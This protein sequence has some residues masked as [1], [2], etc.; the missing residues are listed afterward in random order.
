MFKHELKVKKIVSKESFVKMQR[1]V[2]MIEE[3]NKVMNL[4]GF[5][6]EDL[7]REG[8]YESL[9]SLEKIKANKMLDIGA[10]VG[11]PSIPFS[12]TN[13]KVNITIIEPIQKRVKFL[14]EVITKLNLNVKVIIGRVEESTFIEYFDFITARAVMSLDK[15]IEVSSAVGTIG[16][17]YWFIKGPKVKDELLKASK[18]SSLLNVKPKV[19][20]IN[21][22]TTIV[23]YTKDLRT[24]KGYPRRWKQIIK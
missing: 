4:T 3:K 1:Y 17:R 12:I 8:I 11:F 9:I 2:E 18:I 22:K 19:H 14:K 7:W 5:S 21:N 10:G 20:K 15:L 24:P 16:A 13:P 6:G 23:E